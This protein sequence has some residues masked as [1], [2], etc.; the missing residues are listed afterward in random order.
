MYPFDVKSST[1][2]TLP[3]CKNSCACESR[4]G[5]ERLILWSWSSNLNNV[6]MELCICFHTGQL[7]YFTKTIHGVHKQDCMGCLVCRRGIQ[8]YPTNCG[9]AQQ[10]DK[11]TSPFSWTSKAIT[12]VMHTFVCVMA[13]IL[14]HQ[15]LYIMQTKR[16]HTSTCLPFGLSWCPLVGSCRIRWSIASA[17]ISW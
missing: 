10:R 17:Y 15:Q 1:F 6:K 2:R 16:W 13:I 8:T 14:R 7:L 5:L 9:W 12:E 3:I 4:V 11:G